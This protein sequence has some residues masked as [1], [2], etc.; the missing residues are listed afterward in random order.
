MY[1]CT[2]ISI[3]EYAEIHE[4]PFTC[5]VLLFINIIFMYTNCNIFAITR[6][7]V[8][9]GL[10]GNTH[11]EFQMMVLSLWSWVSGPQLRRYARHFRENCLDGAREAHV[12]SPTL[13]YSI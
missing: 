12:T 3:Y 11:A 13:I 8:L 1:V 2:R 4:L 10:R 7:I 5:I 9:W 6:T